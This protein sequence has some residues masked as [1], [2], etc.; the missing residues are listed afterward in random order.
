MVMKMSKEKIEVYC[1]PCGGTGVFRGFAEPEGVGVICL[2][3]GGTGKKTI[4]IE[5]FEN[6]RIRDDVETVQHSRGAFVLNCGPV[7]K[8]VT[9]KEFLDGQMPPGE[10]DE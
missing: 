8:S 7:G 9:Y 5:R 10:D 3:C 2:E 6:R 1:G 4:T